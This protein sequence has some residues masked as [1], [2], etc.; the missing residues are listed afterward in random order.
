MVKSL[1]RSYRCRMENH[2]ARIRTA[3][4]TVRLDEWLDCSGYY[5]LLSPPTSADGAGDDGEQREV[6]SASPS[7]E[8]RRK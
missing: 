4:E 5:I 8:P 1:L 2:H 6:D 7:S 3:H